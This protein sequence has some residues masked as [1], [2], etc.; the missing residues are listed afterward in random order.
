[1][2]LGADLEQAWSHLA[3]TT[4]T[5]KR[6][7]RAVLNEIVVRVVD[8]YITTCSDAP[9]GP[10][11]VHDE[12]IRHARSSNTRS[13]RSS[14][15]VSARRRSRFSNSGP[16]S[17]GRGRCV[18]SSAISSSLTALPLML[19]VA[20]PVFAGVSC[21]TVADDVVYQDK[22]LKVQESEFAE[23]ANSHELD[24]LDSLINTLRR[25][26]D[27]MRWL[28]EHHCGPAKEEPNA[29]KSVR[30]IELTLTTLIVRRMDARSTH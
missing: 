15:R 6:I 7:V 19:L 3:A 4:P 1:M 2:R 10:Q 18:N 23:F 8:G 17:S 29:I 22:I 26:I 20:T 9:K 11:K 12:G 21:K 5:R 16:R 25:D 24:R 30:D 28:I 13:A 14:P 27:G